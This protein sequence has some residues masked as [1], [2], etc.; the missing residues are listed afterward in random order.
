MCV[1]IIKSDEILSY[2]P[3]LSFEEQ[4]RDSQEVVI[5]CNI[6][7]PKVAKFLDEVENIC[8]NGKT[9]PIT[10]YTT[11]ITRLNLFSKTK[12]LNNELLLNDIVGQL[13]LI[14]KNTDVK[15]KELS[16]ICLKGSCG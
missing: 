9:L 7:C 10:L 3:E 5:D 16:D 1:N 6:D 11:D 2:K 13:A 15:L 8:R 4:I 12:R 14:H